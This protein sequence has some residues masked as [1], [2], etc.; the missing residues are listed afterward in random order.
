[1]GFKSR[2]QP[3]RGKS[4]GAEGPAFSAPGGTDL[5]VDS[6]PGVADADCPPV[7]IKVGFDLD[8]IDGSC[9]EFFEHEDGSREPLPPGASYYDFAVSATQ[10]DRACRVLAR[11]L[12]HQALVDMALDGELGDALKREAKRQIEATGHVELGA[13]GYTGDIE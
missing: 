12:V 4:D 9:T 2:P 1:M 6:R 8:T 13:L 5:V 10:Q 3:R 11:L 7:P